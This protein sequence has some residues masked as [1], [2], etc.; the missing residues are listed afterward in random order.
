MGADLADSPSR[1]VRA[2]QNHRP[3]DGRPVG[4]TVVKTL[5]SEAQKLGIKILLNTRQPRSRPNQTARSPA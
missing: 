3:H 4:V 5:N 1:A 2:F